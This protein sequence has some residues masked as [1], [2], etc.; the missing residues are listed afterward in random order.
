MRKIHRIRRLYAQLYFAQNGKYL[1]LIIYWNTNPTMTQGTK[2]TAVAGGSRE[3]PP[4]R[5]LYSVEVLLQ[6]RF[7]MDSREA[8]KVGQ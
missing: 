3:V 4:N 2:L 7:V 6:L 5:M 8:E 1:L